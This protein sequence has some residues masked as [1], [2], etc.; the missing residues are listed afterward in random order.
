MAYYEGPQGDFLLGEFQLTADGQPVKIA[1]AS[2]SY[3]KNHFGSQAEASFAIDG[4]P[5]TGWSCAEGQ[6]R[7]TRLYS[8]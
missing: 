1:K 2:Q 3:A 6:G 4:N 8:S 5:E 7:P